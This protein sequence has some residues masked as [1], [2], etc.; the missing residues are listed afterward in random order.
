[1]NNKTK[2]WESKKKLLKKL[3]QEKAKYVKKHNDYIND[4]YEEEKLKGDMAVG[5]LTIVC[6]V[7]RPTVSPWSKYVA[8]CDIK[9]KHVENSS[10]FKYAKKI[11][12]CRKGGR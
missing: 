2:A 3:R 9:I 8:D 4:K 5:E 6:S 11:A 10:S 12:K 1:M 7:S